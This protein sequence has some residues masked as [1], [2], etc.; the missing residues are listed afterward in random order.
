MNDTNAFVGQVGSRLR[1]VLRAGGR[2]ELVTQ[3]SVSECGLASLAMVLGYHGRFVPLRE[4]RRDIGPMNSGVTMAQLA[5]AAA[6]H[7]LRARAYRVELE[8]LETLGPAT[9]LHWDLDHFVVLGRRRGARYEVFDPSGA[10]FRLTPDEISK[11]FTGVVMCFEPQPDFEAREAR[12]Y[13]LAPHL[14]KVLSYKRELLAATV[15]SVF[16]QALGFSIPIAFVIAIQD[17]IPWRAEQQLWVMGAGILLAALA[18]SWAMVIRSRILVTLDTQLESEMRSGFLF[19][20]MHLPYSFHLSISTGDLLQRVNSHDHVREAISGAAL[21]TVLD[22]GAAIVFFMALMTISPA[23]ALTVLCVA[24]VHV[25]VVR[26][27]RAMRE[28]AM[29]EFLAAEAACQTRQIELMSAIET[30]K[31]MGRERAMLQRWA[32]PFV[33]L[34][35]AQRRRGYLEAGIS[36]VAPAI[37]M[38][39][40]AVVIVIGGSLVARGEMTLGALFAVMTLAPAF[41][42]PMITLVGSMEA[43]ADARSVAVRINDVSAEPSELPTLG[44][45]RPQV[46]LEKAVEFRDVHFAYNEGQP[47]LA[48]FNL[49]IEPGQTVALVGPTGSGKST[50]AKLLLGLHHPQQGE[51]VWGDTILSNS[52]LLRYRASLGVVPQKVALL[53]ASIRANI[54][55]GAEV[56]DE[57]IEAAAR[58][59][60]LHARVLREP[61]GYDTPVSEGG[62]SLSGG[63]A[64]R[65]ALARAI[66]GKPRLLVLDE[67]TSALDAY[68]ERLIHRRLSE[69]DTTKVIIAHRLSTVRDAGVIVVMQ[70]GRVVEQGDH[71]SLLKLGGL[72]CTLVMA[73]VEDSTSKQVHAC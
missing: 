58:L 45:H 62:T 23:I 39:V 4:L 33:E 35:G 37:E 57:E 22:A 10:V 19:H 53:E 7:R 55:F 13:P 9:I 68:T 65:L 16:L 44:V 59:A 49:R 5:D 12:S 50:V 41:M 8:E 40:I 43:L 51:V 66:V 52:D 32:S 38:T 3:L 6:S 28:R 24:L 73:Q 11:H 20:L 71:E 34:L 64:Q 46:D 14:R 70:N 69:L 2:L 17:I 61:S 27:T 1:G 29:T 63:E 30:I 25:V 36:A 48:G 54:A 72:Y 31:A 42:T 67:A 21:A 47:V 15:C 56:G 60:E 26:V 18:K